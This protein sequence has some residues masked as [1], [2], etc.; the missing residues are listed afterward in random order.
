MIV[1]LGGRHGS[2]VWFLPPLVTT[3]ARIDEVARSFGQALAAASL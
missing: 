2:V 3:P 1:E